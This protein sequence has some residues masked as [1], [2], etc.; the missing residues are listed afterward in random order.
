VENL[1][2]KGKYDFV[3]DSRNIMYG[4]QQ[5]DLTEDVIKALNR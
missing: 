2:K 4:K 1:G 3:F 5:F